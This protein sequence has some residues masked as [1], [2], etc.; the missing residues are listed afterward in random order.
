MAGLT[1]G[2]RPAS[3]RRGRRPGRAGQAGRPEP[4][5]RARVASQPSKAGSRVARSAG[6][7][8]RRQPA[9]TAT[10]AG[11]GRAARASAGV[12][13]VQVQRRQPRRHGQAGGHAR[14]DP[15]RRPPP[16]RPRPVGWSA[17]AAAC[18][19]SVRAGRARRRRAPPPGRSPAERGEHRVRRSARAPRRRRCRAR[20]RASA[21]A[22]VGRGHRDGGV[23]LVEGGEQVDHVLGER[24]PP[25]RRVDPG[26]RPGDRPEQRHHHPSCHPPTLAPGT[27]RPRPTAD[28]TTEARDR[29]T[30]RR[31]RRGRSATGPQATRRTDGADQPG[32]GTPEAAATPSR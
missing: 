6:P 5:S 32:T 28:P 31:R 21:S 30:P 26:R 20:P 29:R 3:P 15:G 12:G 25:V 18:R 10:S 1:A 24:G 14:A 17:A 22:P 9:V 7:R 13:R 11:P 4:E 27:A 19:R 16:A 8:S 2:P 23:H